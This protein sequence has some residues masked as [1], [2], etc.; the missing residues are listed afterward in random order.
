MQAKTKTGLVISADFILKYLDKM[1]TSFI[2]KKIRGHAP[3][4]SLF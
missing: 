1:R 3:R 4:I 2:Y